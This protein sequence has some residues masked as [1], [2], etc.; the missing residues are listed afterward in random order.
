MGRLL[1]CGFLPQH[2]EALP[3]LSSPVRNDVVRARG[4][5]CVRAARRG[6]F[7]M[8]AERRKPAAGAGG[9]RSGTRAQTLEVHAVELGAAPT[10][11]R[12]C[13]GGAARAAAGE[14]LST[15][16]GVQPTA[17]TLLLNQGQGGHGRVSVSVIALC[18]T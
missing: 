1:L 15:A 5:R 7:A 3:S 11:R 10:A 14:R 8:G 2:L 13:G 6:P 4:R 9:T 16:A 12:S 18:G 17:R